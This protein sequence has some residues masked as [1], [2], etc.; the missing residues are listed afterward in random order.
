MDKS[1]GSES[2]RLGQGY[3]GYSQFMKI[4]GLWHELKRSSNQRRCLDVHLR[5]FWFRTSIL[6]P[7]ERMPKLDPHEEPKASDVLS[8]FCSCPYSFNYKMKLIWM[9]A[10][11]SFWDSDQFTL[12]IVQTMASRR[13]N[14]V[15]RTEW[16]KKCR[17]K[18]SAHICKSHHLLW[19]DA[20]D[21]SK[22]KKL[23][24]VIEAS[25]VRLKTNTNDPYTWEKM[26]E[27]EHLFSKNLSDLSIGQLKDL[28]DGVD[29]SF[30]A[31]WKAPLQS[32][33]P[34]QNGEE[35]VRIAYPYQLD[36]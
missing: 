11:Y 2:V 16:N 1:L 17:E 15:K 24:I 20:T 14:N 26:D 5:S 13:P 27:K 23:G 21:T 12:R 19:S 35:S 7:R 31:I 30:I 28:C 36:V 6:A 29:R 33:P 10:N 3:V 18:L 34:A 8:S 9:V 25:Q 4:A 32:K 22:D